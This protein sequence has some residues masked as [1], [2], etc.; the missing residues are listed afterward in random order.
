LTGNLNEHPIQH[1]SGNYYKEHVFS[2]MMKQICKC[3]KT[4]KIEF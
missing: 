2:A 4:L 3:R 1:S